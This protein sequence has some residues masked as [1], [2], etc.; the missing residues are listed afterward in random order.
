MNNNW[1]APPADGEVSYETL[2]AKAENGDFHQWKFEPF[3]M[4]E[5]G[6]EDVLD[7]IKKYTA[8]DYLALDEKRQKAE[9]EGN[10][11]EAQKCKQKMEEMV[12]AVLEIYRSKDILPIQYFSEWGIM[13]EIEKC[14]A[15][16]AK[17][18]GDTVS[19]GA[20]IGTV[21]CN[22]LF[23]NIFDTPSQHD[24]VKHGAR[25]LYEKFHNDEYLRRAIKFCFS[26]KDGC[27]VPTN[28]M[29]GL[30]LVGSAPTNFRPMNAK[31]VYERF[32]PEG[33][34]IF[35]YCCVDNETEFFNGVE[36][37]SLADYVKGD[38]V[39]QY[40]ED[41]TAELVDPIEYIHYQSD[42]PFYLYEGKSLNSCLT[43]GHDI[44]YRR[45]LGKGGD[46]QGLS[47]E[48][49]KIKQEDILNK[50]FRG[51]I[52]L[53][54]VIDGTLTVNDDLL[55]LAVACQADCTIENTN[56]AKIKCCFTKQRKIKRFEQLLVACNIEYRKV[57][58]PSVSP[59][60]NNSG[61]YFHFHSKELLEI[62]TGKD[63]VFPKEWY[64]LSTHCKQVFLDELF[65]WD[66]SNLE[67]VQT[68]KGIKGRVRQYFTSSLPNAELVYFI[69]N[70]T[71]GYNGGS[72]LRDDIRTEGTI[73]YTLN[74][75]ERSS[76]SGYEHKNGF[77]VLEGVKDKY[78][79]VVPSHMLVLRRKRKMFITGNCGF[80]GRLLGALSSKKNYKYVGTDPCT[81][82]MYHLHELADY[83]E[84][85]TGREN[86]YELHCCGSE[87][88]R[89]PANSVDFA[90][91]SP[92][93]FNLE[94]YS[95]EPTQC[96]NKFPELQGWLEGFVRPTIQNIGYML[97]PGAFYAV[98]IAD[99]KVGSEE[100]AYVDEWKRISA[101]E[102][103]PL[104]DTVY[105]GVTARAGSKEQ[106]AGELKKENILIFKKPMF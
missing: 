85:V 45:R 22:Y 78:C 4:Q 67:N 29:G 93:Y 103:M 95:D 18:D 80:G 65:N 82:T 6:Y 86:S 56:S 17:F 70:T 90:F 11:E 58:A 7:E 20:G 99:F 46:G 104:F 49:Y 52:P 38:K 105:L 47:K 1:F 31:A 41:G 76:Y 48:V 37:K 43:G 55:R 9:K 2:L 73:Y 51:R 23:P 50:D 66:G 3:D 61:V 91:S 68:N 28:V 83:I 39:L 71:E 21:L 42:E 98:N 102:G 74:L 14:I 92:P 33:G 81:E 10:T 13:E 26:Y 100:C 36:W 89:G 32:C 62:F 94:V 79:F 77:T 97:K 54:C 8:I 35:D 87:V 84:Q 5:N 57:E 53:T 40:N 16:K 101:E 59:S 24:L 12:D 15:Y 30:R 75:R 19:C 106:A 64:N 44:V 60:R 63:K 25:S 69:M 27:P 88:F 96:F 72:F 34:V